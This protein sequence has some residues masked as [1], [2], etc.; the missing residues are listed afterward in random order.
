MSI[1]KKFLYLNNFHDKHNFYYLVCNNKVVGYIHKYIVELILTSKISV[2]IKKKQIIFKENNFK[3]LTSVF[4][5]VTEVLLEKNIIKNLTGEKFPC[6]NILGK[7][8]IFNVDRSTVEYLGI[9]GYGVHLVAYIKIKNK[10]YLWIPKRSKTKIVEPNKYD[11]TVAG[12]ISSGETLY[13]ALTREAKE[14]AN[15]SKLL[16]K[17]AFP[18]GTISYNWRNKKFSLRRDTLFLFDIEVNKHFKP[19]CRDG[20][21]ENFKLMQ[22]D[23]AL[24]MIKNTNFFKK[25]CALVIAHFLVRYGLLNK[26]NDTNYEKICSMMNL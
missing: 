15:I 14:E 7:K 24:E 12:G 16:L 25:N 26:D 20:E 6:T 23:I 11:N 8:E 17:K 10:F 3:K 4:E 21:V 9:R 19:I 2:V 18:T 13:Q 1:L 22:S 5:N